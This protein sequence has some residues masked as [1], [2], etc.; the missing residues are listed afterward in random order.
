[1]GRIHTSSPNSAC[2]VMRWRKQAF[3]AQCNVERRDTR[4]VAPRAGE[5]LDQAWGV[6]GASADEGET[7]RHLR[8][9]LSR[10]VFDA[11]AVCSA[12]DQLTP[13]GGQR[14]P[15]PL[16]EADAKDKVLVLTVP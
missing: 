16:D 13:G 2:W 15:I 8:R 10:E 9:C 7:G 14:R 12:L 4:D 1:M 5:T 11:E 3:G 6:A